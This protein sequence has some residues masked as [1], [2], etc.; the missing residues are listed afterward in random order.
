MIHTL[1]FNQFTIIRK[2]L[3]GEKKDILLIRLKE[4]EHNHGYTEKPATQL[5]PHPAKASVEKQDWIEQP[6][7]DTVPPENSYSTEAL[8]KLLK[9]NKGELHL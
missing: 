7:L 9:Q 4:E 3:T 5:T 1:F 8:N 6:F 2:N